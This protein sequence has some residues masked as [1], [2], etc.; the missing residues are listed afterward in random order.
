MTA[1]LDAALQA[2]ALTAA[3]MLALLAF[4]RASAA[5]RHAVL[6]ASLFAVACAPVA[7]WLLP[8]WT[9]SGSKPGSAA[10]LGA[11]V[12][13]REQTTP[14]GTGQPAADGGTASGGTS[15]L[16]LGAVLGLWATG[17]AIHA[18]RRARTRP[19]CSCS[20]ARRGVDRRSTE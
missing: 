4:P 20:T 14:D 13:V 2:T 16:M 11:S 5:V 3:A 15:W 12:Q 18:A 19:P 6:A 1:L 8:G 9:L 17:V 7:M 10:E